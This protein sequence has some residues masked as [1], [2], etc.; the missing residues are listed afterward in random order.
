MSAH[1]A[2]DS[3][4]CGNFNMIESSLEQ[5]ACDLAEA[6]GWI[7]RK[8]RWI[9][10]RNGMDRFF[11]KAGRIVLIEFKRPGEEPRLGQDREIERFKQNGAEVHVVD[12][13]L[14]ALRILGVP[15]A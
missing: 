3:T 13:P 2:T 15:Y 8:L 1:L 12:N 14:A 6:D 9:G 11:L 7:V 10:R 4:T 5:Y